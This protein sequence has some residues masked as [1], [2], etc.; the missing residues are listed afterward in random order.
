[1]GAFKRE[2][3]SVLLFIL[4]STNYKLIKM[5]DFYFNQSYWCEELILHTQ[6]VFIYLYVR[7]EMSLSIYLLIYLFIYLYFTKHNMNLITQRG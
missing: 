2:L 7:K 5:E 4:Y 3:V 1:M 6:R